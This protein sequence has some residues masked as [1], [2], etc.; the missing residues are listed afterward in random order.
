MLVLIFV[1]WRKGS[2]CWTKIAPIL[3]FGLVWLIFIV[4]PLINIGLVIWIVTALKDE[5]FWIS[6][7]CIFFGSVSLCRIIEFFITVRPAM[8]KM[9]KTYYDN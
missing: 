2:K 3:F 7:Y 5:G 6:Q 8:S 1:D 4:L 9:M